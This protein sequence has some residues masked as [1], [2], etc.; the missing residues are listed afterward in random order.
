MWRPASGA[1]GRL[2]GYQ[3]MKAT[4]LRP[5]L[6]IEYASWAFG[7]VGLVCVG[8]CSRLELPPRR[9]MIWSVSRHSSLSEAGS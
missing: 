2:G 8:A 9:G 3:A 4:R 5:L 6:F 1:K 7:L